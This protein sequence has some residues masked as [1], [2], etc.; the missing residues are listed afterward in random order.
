[1]KRQTSNHLPRANRRAAGRPLAALCLV[2]A[3]A[4][5][6]QMKAQ[7]DAVYRME[8]GVAGGVGFMLDD[9]N[10][11]YYGS[12]SFAGGAVMRFLLNPRMAVKANLLYGKTGG[13]TTGVNDFYPAN[14]SAAGSERLNYSY[15]GALYDLSALFEINFLPYGIGA[16]YLGYKRLTPYLQVGLGAT[17]GTAGKAFTANLPLGVGLKFKLARRWNLGLD[18]TI[19]FTL[20]DKLDGLEAP[21]AI[22]TSG[23]R[24]KDHYSFTT[25][26][27][28]YDISPKCPDC[29]RD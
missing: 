28:T 15:N 24:G 3:M 10:A 7:D 4:W 11:K 16:D 14:P 25:L 1:M 21:H 29:N 5:P 18:W 13:N 2:A 27:L 19:H 17:Y 8:V 20:S 6:A 12:T 26:T 22:P 9:T 23:F